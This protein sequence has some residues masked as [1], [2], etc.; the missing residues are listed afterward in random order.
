MAA[1]GFTQETRALYDT[2]AYRWGLRDG[3]AARARGWTPLR[4]ALFC[5]A[6]IEGARQEFRGHAAWAM[7][8]RWTRRADGPGV[9]PVEA[10]LWAIATSTTLIYR[11]EEP[12][13]WAKLS[14]KERMSRWNEA[15]WPPVQIS[16]ALSC[17]PGIPE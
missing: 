7:R 8:E 2:T 1:A 13:A 3:D 16:T 15:K 4:V 5:W 12:Q 11:G 9:L 17:E 10:V 6:S 14:M